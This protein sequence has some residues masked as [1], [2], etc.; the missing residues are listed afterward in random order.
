M[1]IGDQVP[2]LGERLLEI[3]KSAAARDAPD[4]D[5]VMGIRGAVLALLVVAVMST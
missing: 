1:K 5:C 2:L 3:L 4:E